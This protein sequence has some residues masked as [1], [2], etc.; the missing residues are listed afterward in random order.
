M[1]EPT[2]FPNPWQFDPRIRQSG[3]VYYMADEVL[4]ATP[5]VGVVQGELENE[6]GARR[7]QVAGRSMSR[8]TRFVLPGAGDGRARRSTLDA[9]AIVRRL[10]NRPD[11]PRVGLNHVF[12]G[13]GIFTG[14]P[15][16]HGGAG[17]DPRPTPY[18]LPAPEAPV[19]GSR[20]VKVAI[21]DTGM[22]P[23]SLALPIF[24]RHALHGTHE[25]D[26]VYEN[27]ATHAISLMGGHGTAVAGIVAR[28]AP[29][30]EL[31][32]IQVLNQFGVTDELNLTAAIGRAAAA[33]AE[34]VVMS[35]GGALLPEES[36]DE[37]ATM[38]DVLPPGT[39][40]VAAAGNTET[41]I[42]DYFPA[43]AGR[44]TSVA[45]IDTT[46]GQKAPAS[47]SNSGNWIT[48]CTPGVGVHCAYPTG[49]WNYTA[50]GVPVV[51][52]GY[53]AWSGTSFSA[54]YLAAR[55]AA[56][57]ME[58]GTAADAAEKLKAGLTG[59]FRRYGG[60]LDAPPDF[61]AP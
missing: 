61:L 54:P 56:G 4:V 1:P 34:I 2:E 12:A 6:L 13:N 23:A 53:I 44:V 18:P 55:I 41:E 46:G 19:E 9:P 11:R 15:K 51:S 45:A 25:P 58:N 3:N 29:N 31:T 33:G 17:T 5:D 28:Y 37:L 47:F 43:R 52:N 32:S 24:A 21:L 42:E 27:P 22:D 30:A 49:T 8:V 26:T 50:S 16:L 14:Q 10:R 60:F 20:P 48:A 35:L 59:G 39:V 36:V 40:L 7:P 57:T 38:F